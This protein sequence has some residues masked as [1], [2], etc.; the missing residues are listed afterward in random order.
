VI[1]AENLLSLVRN[2]APFLFDRTWPPAEFVDILVGPSPGEDDLHGYF[3]VCLAAHHATVATF[4]PTD[5]D[6]K[7]RGLLWR[8]TRDIETL[9]RMADL[10]LR[11][12]RW[13][14]SFVS[15]RC[16]DN[17]FG[18]VSGHDGERMSVVAG[19]L[20][21]F[22]E[23]GDGEYAERMALCLEAELDR[24]LAS[25]QAARDPIES[26]K[27]AQSIAHNLG[28]MNQGIS[29]WKKG[30]QIAAMR[31]RFHRLGHEDA[32]RFA[33]PMKLYRDL[34]AAEGHRNYPLRAVEALR[35]DPS[36]LYP[37]PPFVED[38][39]AS[40]ATSPLLTFDGRR[41][42]VGALIE[43]CRKLPGQQGYYRALAGFASANG[44]Q[45]E[46][47]IEA[48][49]ATPRKDA[50]TAEFRRMLAVP[51]TSFESAMAKRAEAILKTLRPR[52]AGSPR[53]AGV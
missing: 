39:G 35:Q 5:V 23:V 15:R 12:M 27:L 22:V 18:P 41:D 7:I 42:T 16:V 4:V 8:E 30:P 17:G 19:A 48:L 1:A 36:L 2:T 6:S 11:A 25:F 14:L 47:A 3:A 40:I 28:D 49:P 32:G 44:M 37:Q 38:W 52:T 21:R 24:E 43:G 46:R 31:E 51:R 33:A 34:L 9:R 45:F 20:G 10:A 53:S 50:R 13:D 26:L 29:F